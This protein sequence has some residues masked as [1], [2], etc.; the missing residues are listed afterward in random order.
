MQCGELIMRICSLVW[1]CKGAKIKKK[2][3]Q[4]LSY[5]MGS[6]HGLDALLTFYC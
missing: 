3:K 1:I 5:T 2:E 4:W 6:W